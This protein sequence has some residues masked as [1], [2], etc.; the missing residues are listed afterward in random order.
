MSNSA[1]SAAKRRRAGPLLSSPLFQPPQSFQ[2][3]K[4]IPD[5]NLN[6]QPDRP[7]PSF[8]EPQSQ[9]P[10]S[11][12]MTV[13]QVIN[14]ITT[15]LIAVENFVT[16]FG[17]KPRQFNAV[18]SD[19]TVSN[20]VSSPVNI[21]YNKIA[22][23]CKSLVDEHISEFDHRYAVLAEEISN[24][25]NIVLN[26]QSYTMEVN[27]V[28]LE[29]RVQKTE[30]DVEEVKNEY[31]NDDVPNIEFQ[32]ESEASEELVSA[33]PLVMDETQS[34][35]TQSEPLLLEQTQ[36]EPLL[37]EQ[38]LSE[39]TVSTELSLDETPLDKDESPSEEATEDPFSINIVSKKNKKGGKKSKAV[40][41]EQQ[42]LA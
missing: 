14:L 7:Q 30:T 38:T 2:S 23:I 9:V 22:E 41:Q 12:F 33:E 3:N 18:V 29:E 35:E 31:A 28:L 15:R 5:N 8:S 32:F 42:L 25:K 10:D 34:E 20:A 11:K 40:E 13:Q 24:L 37:L 4:Q 1:T 39:S 36:P 6:L 16:E 27:K 21:D 26:L 17:D 19:T